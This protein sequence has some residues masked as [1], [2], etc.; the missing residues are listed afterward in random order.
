MLIVYLPFTVIPQNGSERKAFKMFEEMQDLQAC[1][2]QV[3][4]LGGIYIK[5]QEDN[6][7][8]IVS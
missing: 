8:V 7:E 2:C 6:P 3:V 5:T 4:L 1:I